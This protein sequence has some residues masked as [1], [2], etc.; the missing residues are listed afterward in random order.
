MPLPQSTSSMSNRTAQR[1][2]LVL[3]GDREMEA[4]DIR[5]DPSEWTGEDRPWERNNLERERIAAACAFQQV[6]LRAVMYATRMVR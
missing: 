1:L 2:I 5:L 3:V 6:T 4:S